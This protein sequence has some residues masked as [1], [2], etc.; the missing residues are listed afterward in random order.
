MD[1][2]WSCAPVGP[3]VVAKGLHSQY[4]KFCVGGAMGHLPVGVPGQG[5]EQCDY[6]ESQCWDGYGHNLE[7]CGTTPEDN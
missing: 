4:G 1:P 7:G 6:G 5:P 3:S 2:P